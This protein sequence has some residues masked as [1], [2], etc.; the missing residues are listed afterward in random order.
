[1]KRNDFIRLSILAAIGVAVAP[2]IKFVEK[3]PPLKQTYYC[4][5][6]VSQELLNDKDMFDII[7]NE[8]I[9]E[10][11]GKGNLISTEIGYQ[12]VDFVKDIMTVILKFR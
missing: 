3:L 11:K 6:K 5:F 10:I 12:G 2:A 8:Q 4:R 7:L 9:K 1:M